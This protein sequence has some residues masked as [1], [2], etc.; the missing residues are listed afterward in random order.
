MNRWYFGPEIITYPGR[1]GLAAVAKDNLV[2]TMGGLDDDEEP[3][4]SVDVLDLS[5]ESP[6]WKSTTNMLVKRVDLEVGVIN[7]YLYAV[8][9]VEL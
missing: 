1:A 6:F 9:N 5:S 4:Q 2:F 7:N 8:S 3:L